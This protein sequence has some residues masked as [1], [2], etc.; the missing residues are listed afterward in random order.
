MNQTLEEIGKTI[1]NFLFVEIDPIR[2]KADSRDAGLPA[3]I[4]DL[5]PDSFTKSQFGEIPSEWKFGTL[6]QI[7][8]NVRERVNP[9]AYLRMSHMSA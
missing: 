7:V 4:A 9:K 6:S 3:K 5:F 1:I 8:L 2:V